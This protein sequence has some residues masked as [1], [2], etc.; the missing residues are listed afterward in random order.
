MHPREQIVHEAEIDL[1]DVIIDWM[2]RHTELTYVEQ[3]VVY[4]NVAANS[5]SP[6]KYAL[7]IERHGDD[8][9]PAGLE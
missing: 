3:A 5:A 1:R 4:A 9:T 6:L 2:R 8:Q 7:R